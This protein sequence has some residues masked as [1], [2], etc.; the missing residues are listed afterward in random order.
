M[1]EAGPHENEQL[2]LNALLRLEILDTPHEA[3][4]DDIAE[5][6]GELCGTPIAAISLVDKE[7]QW[8]KANY[9][10]NVRE[11]PRGMAFCAHAIHRPSEPLLVSDASKDPRFNDNPL[12]HN[13]PHIRFYAGVPLVTS[14]DEMPV[15]TLCVISDEVMTIDS[16]QRRILSMLASHVERL[17]HLREAALQLA[18]RDMLIDASND[19]IVTW[20]NQEGVLT[21]NTGAENLF[22][23]RRDEA[24]GQNPC[25]VLQAS[26]EMQEMAKGS[27]VGGEWSGE[28]VVQTKT[29]DSV[30][31]STRLQNVS[32]GPN[33]NVYLAICRDVTERQKTERR[34]QLTQRALDTAEDAVIWARESTGEI[35]YAND[36]ASRRY[37]YS[38][39]EF[40]S[41]TVPELYSPARTE[42]EAKALF[43]TATKQPRFIFEGTH[44]AKDGS[45]IPVEVASHVLET[46][47]QTLRCAFVRDITNR[48]AT[49]RQL[50]EVS[51]ELQWIF[52]SLPIGVTTSDPANTITRVNPAMARMFGR[53]VDEMLGQKTEAFYS[54]PQALTQTDH[55]HLASA[56]T[57]LTRLSSDSQSSGE[58]FRRCDPAVQSRR[59][60]R[61]QS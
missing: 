31:L 1:P 28:N 40:L 33:E 34:L 55:C 24:L 16:R 35:V 59:P 13:E 36:A 25:E 12:V 49:R 44:V 45:E 52:D 50:E 58:V 41:M 19:A 18:Q 46:D 47:D 9:G 22:G 2:R 32:V 26:A 29:G 15:G 14:K 43:R 5:L 20:T 3:A 42:A 30:T 8:F 7:R 61:R 60:V 23:F 21:W 27:D 39:E 4:Y 11:T 51:A 17:L 38:P 6:A 56:G 37:Q 48:V 54:T 57:L 53:T 10:L